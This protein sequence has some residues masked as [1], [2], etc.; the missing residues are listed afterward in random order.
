MK[1][2]T[3][4]LSALTTFVIIGGGSLGAVLVALAGR[5]I[6]DAA[7]WVCVITGLTAAAKDV[8]STMALP[9]LSNGNYDAIKRFMDTKKDDAP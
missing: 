4:L 3:I 5:P 9:P 2:F 7:I 8:R 6:S 1:V